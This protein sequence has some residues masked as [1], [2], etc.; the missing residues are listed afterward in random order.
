MDFLS[1]KERLKKT[2]KNNVKTLTLLK[3]QD[4]RHKDLPIKKSDNE[5]TRQETIKAVATT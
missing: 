2:W 4:W 3:K 1:L 5:V